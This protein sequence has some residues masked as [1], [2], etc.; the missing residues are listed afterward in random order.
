MDGLFRTW[1]PDG[2]TPGDLDVNE[3][4]NSVSAHMDFF[5]GDRSYAVAIQH[6][7]QPT[8]NTGTFEKD[9]TPVEEYDHNGEQVILLQSGLSEPPP[10]MGSS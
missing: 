7:T 8:D 10:M 6:F 3:L 4:H 2:F 5:W 1:H 9:D